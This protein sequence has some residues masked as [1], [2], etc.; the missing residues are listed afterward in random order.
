MKDLW[1]GGCHQA[2]LEDMMKEKEATKSSKNLS[3]LDVIK[4]P[5]LR[6]PLF[7]T[8]LLIMSLQLSG[9]SAVEWNK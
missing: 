2:E 7:I 3:V 6:M 4:E 8:I 5:S 9:L 1:G